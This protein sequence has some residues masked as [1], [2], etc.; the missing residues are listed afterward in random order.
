MQR[1]EEK[2]KNI[3]DLITLSNGVN[4]HCMGYGTWRTPAGDETTTAVKNA[5]EC[6]FRHIDTA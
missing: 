5:I 1:M 2:M 6:G 4:I 3:Q